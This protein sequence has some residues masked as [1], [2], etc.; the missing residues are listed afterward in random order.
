VRLANGLAALAE[1]QQIAGECI[2]LRGVGQPETA[3]VLGT[4]RPAVARLLCRGLPHLRYH[5]N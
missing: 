2:H 1:K 3:E 4:N 5:L